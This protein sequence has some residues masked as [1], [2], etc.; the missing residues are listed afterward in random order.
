R[1]HYPKGLTWKVI[2]SGSIINI[3]DA[4]K[5]E[6]VG[7][8]G[9]DLGH[10]SLL[11]IPIF[12]GNDVI[13]VIW[14]LSYKERRFS[15]NEMRRLSAMGD[16]IAI[17]IA[18]AKMLEEI[19]SAQEKLVQSEK[20][21]SLGQLVSSIAHEINNP[22][23]PIIGYS[24]RLL[25][26]PELNENQKKLL[27]IIN[28]S[29]QRV[30][31]IIEK[32]LSFSRKATPRRTYEDIN[33]L[34]EQSLEFMG[35]QL[36]H[37]NI[38]VM[39]DL[40]RG[41]PKTMVDSVQIQQVFTNIIINAEQAIIGNGGGGRLRV[42][43]RLNSDGAIEI[44]FKD[45]GPG[46]AKDLWG[47]VFDPFFTTKEPGKGIGLGLAVAYGIIRE[48]GGE[49]RTV[50][51]EGDGATFIIEL[52]VLAH[53]ENQHGGNIEKLTD[54]H[55]RNKNKR[56]MIVEDEEIVIDLIKGVLE[57][58]NITIDSARNG[59][60]ALEKI[61]SNEYELIVCDI[62]M[63]KMNGIAFYEE[64]KALNPGLAKKVIFITGDPSSETINFL[65]E[66]GNEFITKP[67][68]IDKFKARVFEFLKPD[69]VNSV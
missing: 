4:Q 21:A 39:Q 28:S 23:T 59:E 29:A 1:V 16:Q 60:D 10:H 66:T 42:G 68:K 8:A 63:P 6:D 35:Y 19:K 56:L 34:V 27:E 64:I 36:K 51:R 7:Q 14:F 15:E 3:E 58:V 49:I 41:I 44:S 11:G 61:A 32:L 57:D 13:G 20:L 30:A 22:L 46:I 12:M 45:D 65:N 33:S 18:K 52:P 40:D 67:F 17:A 25:M 53:V 5:D 26:Q 50:S 69:V 62:K 48:H 38:E 9:R 31:E 2:N 55:R 37:E 24:Q 47:K 54:A 43:T